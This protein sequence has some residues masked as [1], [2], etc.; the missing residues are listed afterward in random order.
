MAL[1]AINNLRDYQEDRKVG[2]QTLIAVFGREFG[3]YEYG[4]SVLAAT[5]AP[6]IFVLLSADHTLVGVTAITSLMA[7]HAIR[8]TV[9]YNEPEELLAVLKMTAKLQA[10]F[11]IIFII[12]WII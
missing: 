3:I 12:T 11:T 7:L 2:K 8:V 10:I 5:L 9:N 6:L 4:L 1:L